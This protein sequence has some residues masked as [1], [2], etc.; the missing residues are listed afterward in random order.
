M[1]LKEIIKNINDLGA[2]TQFKKDILKD[3]AIV[4]KVKKDNWLGYKIIG[5]NGY[6]FTYFYKKI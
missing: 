1:T 3:V 2:M 6:G 4:T 5:K